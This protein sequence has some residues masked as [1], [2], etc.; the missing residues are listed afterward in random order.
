M[1]I[2]AL[3]HERKED[4]LAFCRKHRSEVDDSFLYEHDLAGFEVSD[5]N[6]T[7][8][9]LDSQGELLGAAS[10]ILNDYSRRGQKARFR[11]FYAEA[12]GITAYLP[13]MQAIL[14]HV[15]GLHKLNIFVPLVNT[16]LM[17]QM[18]AAGFEVERYSYILV[19]E[20][21]EVP[22]WSLP[23][24]YEI[25]PFRPGIDEAV[26][27]GI[28]NA[29][30]AKLLGSETPATPEMVV[31]MVSGE[32]YLEGGML[33]LYHSSKAVGIVR[34]SADEYEDLP[35]M[36]IGPV[37]LLPEYQGKGL[38]KILLRASLHFARDNGFTRTIL[39]V[40]AENDRAK[41][42]Y[43][44]EGFKQVEAAACLAYHLSS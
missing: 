41:A 12:D 31:K 7:Y 27:C 3:G 42:L 38:G 35:I 17:E 9:A 44:G 20:E 26:W 30:F 10:L 37:A 43:I 39:C 33:I 14:Q 28:R 5:E 4:F 23:S 25:K 18:T 2:E 32:T 1:K 34:G 22:E 36:N 8:I 15:E 24:G 19:R 16:A 11:I 13:L 40:N 6:P 29:G 21:R